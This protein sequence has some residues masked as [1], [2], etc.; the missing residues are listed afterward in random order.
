[1]KADL[2]TQITEFEKSV[3]AIA[4]KIKARGR[5]V[6]WNRETVL[7]GESFSEKHLRALGGGPGIFDPRTK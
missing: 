6:A 1:V 7:S 3:K 2:E 4:S 5:Q